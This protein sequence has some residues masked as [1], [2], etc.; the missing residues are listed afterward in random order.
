[1]QHSSCHIRFCLFI[2][3]CCCNHHL[4]LFL[5]LIRCRESVQMRVAVVIISDRVSAGT[6]VDRTGP[7]LAGFV[8]RQAGWSLV[9]PLAPSQ[10]PP[11]Q[12]PPAVTA[13]VPDTAQA[14]QSA[15]RRLTDSPASSPSHADLVLTSGGT[16]FGVRD[17]TPEAVGALLDRAA[18]GLVAAVLAAG[19]AKTPLAALSRPVAGV[20]GHSVVLTL[21]GSVKGALESVEAVAG[22]LGHAVELAVGEDRAGEAFHEALS[23]GYVHGTAS[24]S[25][26]ASASGGHAHG[27]GHGH[28]GHNCSRHDHMERKTDSA[29]ASA[30]AGFLS[31]DPSQAVTRRA[32]VS[33]YPMISFDAALGL[34]L[35]HAHV[36]EP[37]DHAVN[38]SLISHILAADVVAAENVPAYRASIVDGYAVVAADGPGTYPLAGIATAGSAMATATTSLS[39]G[40]VSRIATG[41]AVPAGADAV[42]MIEATEIAETSADGTEE[43]AV[44]ITESVAPGQDIR[45]IGSDVR[46][47]ETVL[48]AGQTVTAVGGEMGVLASVGV[49]RVAV[50][51]KP[52]VALLST[53]NE[54]VDAATA[55]PIPLGGI[56][57]SNRP[58]LAAV[59]AQAGY[60][61]VDL[62]IASDDAETLAQTIRTGLE[63]ADILITTGGVSMG[64]MDLLKP[65]LER[66]LGATIHFGRVALKPGKP[67]T[68]ATIPAD[69][70]GSGSGN[71]HPKLVFAL[72]GNPVSCLVTYMLFVVPALRRM[73]GW[74][75]PTLP[76]VNVRLA[77]ET[78]LDPRPEFHRARI[79][80]TPAGFVAHST[81]MQR[82]SRVQS[83]STA[84]ALLALP[85]A[86]SSC[87]RLAAGTI[88]E[89]VVIGDLA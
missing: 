35:A 64:E 2:K 34:V 40:F 44:R 41:A 52:V 77:A 42:V 75:V 22:V 51:R 80:F 4:E 32:R 17:V 39:S 33:P 10:P 73:A 69:G 72:P 67:T 88:V 9:P 24:A 23:G 68:F 74:A 6:A 84:N 29:S 13:V 76:R 18:P 62:G 63:K 58:A 78:D 31:N 71:T 21:P 37:V 66:S 82:S 81:G 43:R 25:G 55:G 83:M 27:H 86:S 47:G 59:I 87:R 50:V 36:L 61:V 5:Q 89:A 60:Q 65:V 15:I 16:G 8:Q 12:P 46:A 70:S 54:V 79:V 85:A 53:G 28:G 26:A 45:E 30:S 49:T 1:M 3:P 11:Q 20:R 57:D 7:E 38:A 14:I 48:R 19:L 56:R